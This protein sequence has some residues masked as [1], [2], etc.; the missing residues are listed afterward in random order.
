MGPFDTLLDWMVMHQ[1]RLMQ[2]SILY[3]AQA[4]KELDDT[5]EE[6]GIIAASVAAYLATVGGLRLDDMTGK[7]LIDDATQRI[8][9]ARRNGFQRAISSLSTNMVQLQEYERLFY[10]AAMRASGLPIEAVEPQFRS[11]WPNV[12]GQDLGQWQQR[13][14]ENDAR[15]LQEGL[16]I[17]VRLGENEAALRARLIGHKSYGGR[18]GLVAQARREL[19][20]LVRTATDTFADLARV[21]VDLAN[22]FE[23]KEVYVAV[24]D[25]RTTD[26]CRNLHGRVFPRGQGPRPP[27]HWYCRST[28]VS[29]VG[30]G[31]PS[32]PSY[33][34]W[35]NRL[36]SRDQDEVLGPRQG[37]QFRAGVLE[38]GGF[39][40]PAWWGIDL[41]TMA[42]REQAIFEA[43]GMDVP[44]R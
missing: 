5:E 30:G 23:G 43:A 14:L 16:S 25:S 27:L 7:N 35:L 29:L 38:V 11:I 19:E 41:K 13:L 37:A 18:D 4:Q 3:Q 6:L 34:E 42:E 15:R 36:S 39:R 24:L 12:M 17:G 26:T 1:I 22:P 21:Q 20:T 8:L 32:I 31:T 44:F 2:L 33:R 40:E 28:R 10:S 9:V